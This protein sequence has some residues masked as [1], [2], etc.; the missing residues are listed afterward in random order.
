MTDPLDPSP[1]TESSASDAMALAQHLAFGPLVFQGIVAMRELGLLEL[2]WGERRAGCTL[3]QIQERLGIS[4]Y[5]ATVLCQAGSAC[6]VLCVAEQRYR[7]SKVGYCLL[8]DPMTRANFDFVRDVCYAPA[9]HLTDALREQRPAGLREL[10][11]TASTVYRA[12]GELPEDVRRSWFGFDHFHSDSAFDAALERLMAYAPKTLV[13]VGA[14]TGR[15]A[16]RCLDAMPE[17]HVTL[18]DHPAQ[19]EHASRALA[20]EGYAGR[21]TACELDL[22]SRP[23]RLPG[24]ADAVWLSQVLD[25]FDEPGIVHILTAA[26]RSLSSDG[27]VFV[28]EPCW[29]VQRHPAAAFCLLQTSL[30]FACVA[31][32]SSRMYDSGTL[33]RLMQASGLRVERRHDALGT[34]HS[35]FVCDVAPEL[36]EEPSQ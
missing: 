1:A 18:I 36:S 26:R 27:H 8:H 5:A 3:E 31:N 4:A 22:S 17:V 14:N 10:C 15:F 35:L 13:D 25:C 28:L 11:P 12:L 21:F 30:Y 20:A 33:G 7:L 29:D 23:L 16:K 34:G 2:L 32:G 24:G 9:R 6:G 19:L